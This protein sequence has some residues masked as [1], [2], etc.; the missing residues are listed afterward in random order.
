MVKCCPGC[1]HSMKS[2]PPDPVPQISVPKSNVPWQKLGLNISGPFHTAPRHQ[3]FVV[4]VVD[5][6]SGYPEVSLT[7]DICSATI[8]CWLQELFACYSCPDSIVMDNGPQFV[9]TEF[10][11]F[12]EINGIHP[13]ICAVYNP[14]QNGLVECCN[15]TLKGGVQ[16]FCFWA[17]LGRRECWSCSLSIAIC[18]LH[19]RVPPQWNYCLDTT[20]E[21]LLR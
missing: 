13:I 11:H 12:L 17:I 3:Q 21:W 6:H 4:S 10:Q 7:T 1:Q 15:C 8:I 16:V 19:L 2:Q 18:L 5:Y 14:R 20:H 9:L